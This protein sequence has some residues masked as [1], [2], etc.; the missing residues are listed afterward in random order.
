MALPCING[1]DTP[2]EWNPVLVAK[3][4]SSGGADA[5]RAV[6]EEAVKLSQ[7]CTFCSCHNSTMEKVDRPG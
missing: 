1:G 7:S 5:Q 4:R 2:D 3:F 6:G